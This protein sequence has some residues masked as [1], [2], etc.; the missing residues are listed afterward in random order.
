MNFKKILLIAFIFIIFMSNSNLISEE[1]KYEIEDDV[2]IL[3]SDDID[4][5]NDF[6]RVLEE[7][8]DLLFDENEEEIEDVEKEE[9]KP[10]YL[11]EELNALEEIDDETKI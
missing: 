3:Q 5:F 8:L 10:R 1:N 7:D 9:T 6:R 11:N 4:L 2:D